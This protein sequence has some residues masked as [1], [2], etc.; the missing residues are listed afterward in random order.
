MSFSD[1]IKAWESDGQY[2]NILGFD[3]W[4]IDH[5]PSAQNTLCILHGYP[6]CSFDYKDVLD[7]FPEHR[8]IIHDHLGFG[9]SAK[10]LN[11]EYKLKFQADIA[12]ALY[13]ILNLESFYLFAHNYGTSIATE[14][15]YRENAKALN[16]KIIKYILCNGSMLIDMSKLRPIQKML[17]HNLLGPLVARLASERTF[18][19][20]MKNIWYDKSKANL[21]DFKILWQLIL[22]NNGRKVLP[23]ITKYIDQRFQ[24]YDRWIGALEET[25]KEV[26][27][28]WAEDDPVAVIAM[29]DVLEQK[30]KHSTKVTIEKTGH[31]PMIENVDSFSRFLKA[32]IP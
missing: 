1:V 15:M 14:I 27:I 29:A 32:Y 23:Q 30:I 4:Y 5:N 17:K 25:E 24:H 9:L 21:P 19:R 7:K 13:Q 12:L 18:V 31:Y 20:N 11:N 22:H 2:I 6:T 8:I 28:L 16:F 10:P 3:I 26:L